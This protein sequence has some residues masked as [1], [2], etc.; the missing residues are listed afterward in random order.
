M[1]Q[2]FKLI[3]RVANLDPKQYTSIAELTKE[4][5]NK[6]GYRRDIYTFK[7]GNKRE[8]TFYDKP[9]DDILTAKWFMY[10]KKLFVSKLSKHPEMREYYSFIINRTFM[11]VMQSYRMDIGTKDNI[12]NKNVN[13][14]LA[15]RIGEVLYIMGSN[16]RLEEYKSKER[17]GDKNRMLL[18]TAVNHMAQSLD[19]LQE[20]SGYCPEY[21]DKNMSDIL[22]ELQVKLEDNEFGNRLLEAMLSSNK[23]I[24]P[25]HIDDFIY[26]RREECTE[27]NKSKILD[28]WDKIESVLK[29]YT[30]TSKY[31]WGKTK[32]IGYSFEKVKA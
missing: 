11:I 17:P 15:N 32:K 10:Y 25:S 28:A 4:L 1:Y 29:T 26:M 19:Q 5:A 2:Y 7:N 16:T 3:K 31:R 23:K 12:I 30:D 18:N 20:D 9:F 22:V 27:E 6:A 14:C 21:I 8:R 24:Q 13:M